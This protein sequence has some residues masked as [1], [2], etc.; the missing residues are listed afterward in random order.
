MDTQ[1]QIFNNPQFGVIRTAKSDSGE[2]LFIASDVCSAL[3]YSNSRDAINRHVDIDDRSDVVIHDGSQNRQMTSIN[4]SGVY[5]LIFGSKLDTAKI[6]KK[7]V[8]S[9]VLPS[10]RKNGGYIITKEEEKPIERFVIPGSC[11][12]R[13]KKCQIFSYH[14]IKLTPQLRASIIL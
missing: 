9:E 2:P 7:W 10:I 4:E 3:G 11:L 1:I 6:F 13:R 12:N 5:S 8:T 14:S